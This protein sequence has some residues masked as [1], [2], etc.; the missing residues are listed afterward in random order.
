[1]DVQTGCNLCKKRMKKKH[2]KMDIGRENN[3]IFA[4]KAPKENRVK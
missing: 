4:K 3:V 2:Y 1:M